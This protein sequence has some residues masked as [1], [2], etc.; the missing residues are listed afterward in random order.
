[1]NLNYT[2]TTNNNG[3]DDDDYI[4]IIIILLFILI[5]YLFIYLYVYLFRTT[6]FVHQGCLKCNIEINLKYNILY[7]YCNI[8]TITYILILSFFLSL[9]KYIFYDKYH[10]S[11]YLCWNRRNA[12]G[13]LFTSETVINLHRCLFFFSLSCS[14]VTHIHAYMQMIMMYLFYWEL[15]DD[16][17]T[18]NECTQ[19]SSFKACFP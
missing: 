17:D 1:M 18:V 6:L 2:T 3:N 4:I 8:I 14:Q 13:L 16:C 11:A 19:S 7:I 5:F 15:S 9:E 12:P 10:R